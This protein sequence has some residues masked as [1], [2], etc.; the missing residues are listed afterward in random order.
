MTVSDRSWDRLIES[1]VGNEGHR[2]YGGAQYHR[3]IREFCLAVKCLRLPSISDDEIANAA[4]MGTTHD[5]VNFLHAAC[6]IALEKARISF[7]PML[8]ALR[9]RVTHVMERLCPVTEY[10][11]RETEERSKLSKSLRGDNNHVDAK[12]SSTEFSGATDISQNPQFRQLL[13]S[14]FDKF[15]QQCSDS[16]CILLLRYLLPSALSIGLTLCAVV[17]LPCIPKG[18]GQDSR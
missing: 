14:I 9:F 1:D 7:E 16:V 11:L 17:W 15:V 18:D 8:E 6:V 3:V 5:G 10:M 13:R 4:G 2:L 12:G